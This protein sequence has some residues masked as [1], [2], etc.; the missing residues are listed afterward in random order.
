[1]LYIASEYTLSIYCICSVLV[2][3]R[4]PEGL[5]YEGV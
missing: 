1:M 2:W 3:L 5:L 4:S